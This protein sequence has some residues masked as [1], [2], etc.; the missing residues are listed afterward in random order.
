MIIRKSIANAPSTGRYT[1]DRNFKVYNAAIC[2]SFHKSKGTETPF[3]AQYA[4]NV[5]SKRIGKSKKSSNL[6]LR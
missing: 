4:A 3:A 1:T 5:K 6:P 2:D